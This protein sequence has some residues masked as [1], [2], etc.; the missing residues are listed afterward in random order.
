MARSPLACVAHFLVLPVA[1]LATAASAHGA[2]VVEIIEHW[3][4]S[5]GGPETNISAPQVT[6]VMS[7][8]GDTETD[9]FIVALNHWSS[10]EFGAG[11]VQVQHWTGDTASDHANAPTTSPLHHDGETVRWKQRMSIDGGEVVFEVLDG[12]SQSWGSFAASGDLRL[13]VDAGVDRLNAYLP[14]V[15]LTESGIGYAG[16]RVSSLILEKLQWRFA[17]EEEFNEMVAP[18]DIDADLDP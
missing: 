11:G 10:P 9:Y 18:I 5:V 2:D 15:S 14:A 8:T 7:P 17:G 1:L 3:S 6:M 13:R 4:L 12:T 16:N